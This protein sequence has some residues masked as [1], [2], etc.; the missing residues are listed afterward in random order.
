MAHHFL[1]HQKFGYLKTYYT[2]TLTFLQYV[3]SCFS[4]QPDNAN[5]WW[6]SGKQNLYIAAMCKWVP[7]GA[8][9]HA[10]VSLCQKCLLNAAGLLVQMQRVA[11]HRPCQ[12]ANPAR[13]VDF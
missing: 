7:T 4:Y 8:T 3:T 1:L 5:T 11:C 12:L 10:T 6:F 13:P 9:V 2:C